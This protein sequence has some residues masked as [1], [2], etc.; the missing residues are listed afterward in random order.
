MG[1]LLYMLLS[2]ETVCGK[3]RPSMSCLIVIV[4]NIGFLF[5]IM[6]LVQVWEDEAPK[7]VCEAIRAGKWSF[8]QAPCWKQKSQVTEENKGAWCWGRKPTAQCH[9]VPFH[10]KADD[11]MDDL[12]DGATRFG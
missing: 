2:G 9:P 7:Q 3:T 11:T 8:D 1:V 5:F 6:V 4:L 10:A 12:M